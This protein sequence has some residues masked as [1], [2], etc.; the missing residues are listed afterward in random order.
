MSR[1]STD[2]E[3]R[4]FEEALTLFATQGFA[5][6]S[7]REI[8]EAVGLSKPVL[9]YYFDNKIDLFTKLVERV[10]QTAYQELEQLAKSSE[11][12]AKKL[13]QII[14]QTYAFCAN[15]W[16]V[17]R[18]MY[19]ASFGVQIPGLE[20]IMGSFSDRR[21]QKIK[22]IVIDAIRTGEFR[23][24]DPD[25]A[26]IAFC[27]LMDHPCSIFTRDPESAHLLTPEL[28]EAQFEIFLRGI[29]AHH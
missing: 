10:H 15:D 19:S 27:S 26:T 23:Q 7:V 5:A 29:G 12:P 17:P 22:M 14:R 3:D 6:T 21:Y 2:T 9:Y 1:P 18:M 28:A 24:T 11:S 13:R 16:R 25:V 20:E 8:I 4:L